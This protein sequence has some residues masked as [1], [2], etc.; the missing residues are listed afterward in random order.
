MLSILI[1]NWNTRELLRSC[2]ASLERFPYSGE[3]ETIVVDN[4]SDDGSAEMVKQDFPRVI[5]VS[6]GSNTGYASGNNLAFSH[7]KGDY[8]LTL[9]PDTEFED[10][11]LDT[12]VSALNSMPTAGCLGIRLVLPGKKTQESVRGFPSILG[13]FGA[14]TKLDR[15]FPATVL[16]SYSV[17]LFDYTAS[18]PAPQPMGTFLLFRREALAAVGDP[19]APF[20]P[21]FPIFFNE[22]DLLYRLAKAGWP[23]HFWAEAHVLHHHGASTRQVKKSMIWESHNSLFRYFKKHLKGSRRLLLPLLGAVIW[24]AAFVRAQGHHAGF[25]P[26]HHH[27]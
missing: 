4:D 12:A 23:A 20:D 24:V 1:V 15:V 22:V 9:N 17:P 27:L 18:G 3:S 2:L 14:L 6:P 11:S 16:G 19:R 8:L 13:V 26:Q 10:L 7:A 21:E 25:R 5:L